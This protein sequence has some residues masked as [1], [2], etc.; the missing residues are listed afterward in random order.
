[1]RAQMDYHMSLAHALAVRACH[2]MV[3]GGKLDHQYQ[4]QLLTHIQTSQKM[5]GQQN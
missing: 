5:Y 1:M 2:E 4:L 3:E